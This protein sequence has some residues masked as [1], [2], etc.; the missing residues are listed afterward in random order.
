MHLDVGAAHLHDHRPDQRRHLLFTVT[1]T[2]A[3][4][5]GAASAPL[6]PIVPPSGVWTVSTPTSSPLPR[7]TSSEAWDPATGQLIL[8]GGGACSGGGGGCTVTNDTWSWTGTTWTELTPSTSP[9]P[10]AEGSLAYDPASGQLVLFGGI[11]SGGN[12]LS[13]T[14]VWTGTNWISQSPASSPPARHGATLGYDPSTD[15]LILFGGSDTSGITPMPSNTW[16]WD[17]TNWTQLAPSTS[18]PPLYAATMDWDSSTGQLILFGGTTNGTYDGT[19]ETWTW[20]GSNWDELTPASSPPARLRASMAMD[21][22]TGQLL[23]FGG[24]G[25]GQVDLGDMWAWDGSTWTEL[26]PPSLPTPRAD[27]TM[28]FD[29]ATGTM[30]LFGGSQLD[31]ALLL[32]DTWLYS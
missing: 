13:A 12:S 31:G 29:D 30:V 17:G 2:N 16:A 27:A 7:A 28:A 10:L 11:D 14:W 9:P 20:T 25:V 22:V 5:T 23:L 24:Y 15:Q 4:G 8:F 26:N 19:N 6:G 18:P 21:P 1:A 32:G 3:A